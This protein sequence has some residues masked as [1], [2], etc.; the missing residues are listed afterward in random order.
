[1]V[2]IALL[3]VSDTR[4]IKGDDSGNYLQLE[5]E[6][7]GHKIRERMICKDDIYLI[8]KYLS[9]WISNPEIDVIITTGG[10]GI[11][12]RDVTPEA[13][14]PLLDKEIDGFG[15]TFRFLS[16]QRIGTSTLQSR[17]IAGTANGKFL[18]IL[19]GSKDAVMT[20]WQDIISHQLNESTKPCNLVNLMD[21]LRE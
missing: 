16:F 20:G 15:E 3:T 12:T 4:N 19:P 18:F 6:N 14:K 1:M 8:R 5:T 9:D 11:T 10:T 21:R 2:S 17:C 7:S 13:V